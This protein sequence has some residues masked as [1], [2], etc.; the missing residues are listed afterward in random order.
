M[1][2]STKIRP[3]QII[4]ILIQKRWYIFIPFIVSMMIGL[5]FAFTLPKIYKAK[6][7]ILVQPQKVPSQF[8][9]SLVS[10]D[11]GERISA[12]SE[13]IMSRTN[14]EKI[15]N[16]FNLFSQKE[17]E[18]MYME[19]MIG[20]LRERISVDVPKPKRGRRNTDAISISFK[21]EKPIQITNV[22]NA[23]TS[24]F[25]DENLKVREEQAI[26]TSKFLEDEL[27]SMRSRLI[28]MEGDLKKYREENMGSLPE[29][30]ESNLRI[31]DR[32][33][34][35]LNNKQNNLR[36]SK[37][38]L[39]SLNKQLEE[40][41]SNKNLFMTQSSTQG[42]SA[43][44]FSFSDG[45]NLLALKRQL[46]ELETKYTPKHPDVVRLKKKIKDLEA[47][48]Q[49]E[50]TTQQVESQAVSFNARNNPFFRMQMSMLEQVEATR[51]D[52]ISLEEEIAQL[53]K[54]IIVYQRRIEDIPKKEQEL[55][56]LKRDYDEVNETY[57]SLLQ[58]KLEAELAVNMEKKQKGEQF[59]ILDPA[60]VPRKPVEPNMKRLFFFAVVAGLGI[61]G[62]LIY[63]KEYYA[64]YFKTIDE[65]EATLDLP[66]LAVIPTRITQRLKLYRRPV[67]SN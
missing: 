27:S 55:L 15:I 40:A 44:S 41:E 52:I 4:E 51:R 33:Q 13:Q 34:D 58:R 65:I 32:L 62:G 39:I 8:V 3:E 35:E 6:T 54:K 19:D 53:Q 20:L 28:T 66:V 29:Q 47:E 10:S 22:A 64:D 1:E 12:I 16:E 42:G 17:R 59:C 37:L 25:I 43:A 45:D 57:S 48:N 11:L 31:V 5:Y 63:L 9:V 2:T 61:G 7:I 23:L 46:S 30:L 36:D 26:G 60:K 67:V 24:Y 21:G 50:E 56:S 18:T 49:E 38:L 14:L